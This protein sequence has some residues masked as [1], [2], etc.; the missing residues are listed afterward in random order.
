[1]WDAVQL[2]QSVQACTASPGRTAVQQQAVQHV[3]VTCSLHIS[4]I[5]Y[6]CAVNLSGFQLANMFTLLSHAN[7]PIR[8]RE[9]VSTLRCTGNHIVCGQCAVHEQHS[10]HAPTMAVL[11]LHCTLLHLSCSHLHAHLA[12]HV[13]GRG[14]GVRQVHGLHRGAGWQQQRTVCMLCNRRSA[15]W[16]KRL[17][18]M[19]SCGIAVK[20]GSSKHKWLCN[21]SLHAGPGTSW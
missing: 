10:N 19:N 12:V 15:T 4:N 8:A 14:A 17:V 16:V 2:L 18:G 21:D 9:P 7:H 3:H 1:M 13:C 11:C 20:R 5:I 6:H